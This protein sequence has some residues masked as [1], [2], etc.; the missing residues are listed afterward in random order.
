[1]K[2]ANLIGQKAD[3]VRRPLAIA[4]WDFSWLERRW[5]GGG[6]ED[7]DRALDELKERGYDAV[8]IDPYPHFLSYNALKIYTLDPVWDSN[9]WGSPGA[10]RIQVQPSLNQFIRKCKD[11]N[12]R[13]ALSTWFRIDR[14]NVAAGIK[15]PQDLAWIWEKTLSNIDEELHDAIL[16]V[17]LTNEFPLSMWTPY[18][19]AGT[20]RDSAIAGKF[21]SE[22]IA[23][24][25]K[26]FP[27]FPYTFS[28]TDPYNNRQKEDVSCLDFLELHLWMTQFSDYY[29]KINAAFGS[30]DNKGYNR[31]AEFGEKE[32]IRNKSK[33]HDAVKRAVALAREWS[34]KSGKPVATTECWAVVFFK[35]YPM[36]NW[37]WIKELCATG[38]TEAAASGRWIYIA[39][40]NFCGPQFEGMWKNIAWHREMTGI[41]HNGRVANG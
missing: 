2:S 16:Y 41:I 25:K 33:Y 18:L 10:I 31:M 12:I 23:E 20:T 37:E 32:Y 4:M 3:S 22:S 39:T 7:W 21:M 5:T 19:P 34:I 14:D 24:L 28:F 27:R 29:E 35:D 17:D 9:P 8:R 40:S 11:R 30:F 26:S 1:M 36:L 6:Y 13:V 15:T 38:V